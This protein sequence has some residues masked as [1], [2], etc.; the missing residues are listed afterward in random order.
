MIPLLW[1]FKILPEEESVPFGNAVGGGLVGLG[2][3]AGSGWGQC[4]LVTRVPAVLQQGMH[5]ERGCC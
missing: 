5:Q 4:W 1:R 3:A 2:V